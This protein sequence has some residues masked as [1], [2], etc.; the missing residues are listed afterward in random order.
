MSVTRSD[1]PRLRLDPE[2]AERFPAYTGL[3][4]YAFGLVNGPSDEASVGQLRAAEAEARVAFAETRPADHPHIAAWRAAYGAFGAKPSKYPCSVE[5]LLSRTV[6]GQDLPPINRVVDL[7]NAVS[8]RRVLPVGGEDLDALDGDLILGFATG[9]EPFDLSEGEAEISHPLPGEVVWADRRGV[10]CRR[11]NWR[12]GRRTRLTE[13]SRNTYFVL[14]RLAP[15]SIADLRRAA[16]ELIELLA[17][18]SPGAAFESELLGAA[19]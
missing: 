2:V 9:D 14:D 12:Q 18:V 5:A 7:Y 8:L 4:V 1:F 11:W 15:Y 16:D 17:G 3:I 10:T 13:S 19:A 6:K